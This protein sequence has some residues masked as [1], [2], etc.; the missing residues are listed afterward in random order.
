MPFLPGRG[1]PTPCKRQLAV[2]RGWL[3]VPAS[4]AAVGPGAVCSVCPWPE[5]AA[6]ACCQKQLGEKF[7]RRRVIAFALR[8]G[9]CG[10]RPAAVC[11]R[12]ARRYAQRRCSPGFAFFECLPEK[13]GSETVQPVFLLGR[14]VMLK[15]WYRTPCAE[16]WQ[17]SG[18]AYWQRLGLAQ[19]RVRYFPRH[20]VPEHRPV[21]SD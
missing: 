1:E 5:S 4:C 8:L 21:P 12:L 9:L 3:P 6:Q 11:A 19:P 10:P 13:C 16:P 2:R 18:W 15:R 17:M 14:A 7:L 20:C